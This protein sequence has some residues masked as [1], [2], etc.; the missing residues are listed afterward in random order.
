MSEEELPV[1]VAKIDG[2][3]IDDVDLTEAC[4][5]EVLEKLASDPT[6][7]HHQHAGLERKCQLHVGRASLAPRAEGKRAGI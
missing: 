5:D 4:K 6:S 1:E 2:I 3:E 7:A